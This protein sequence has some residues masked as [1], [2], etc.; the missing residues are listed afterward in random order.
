M[1]TNSN[2][3]LKLLTTTRE[4]RRESAIA[5]LAAARRACE[6]AEAAC[7]QAQL[8]TQQA[9]QWREEVLARCTLGEGGTLRDTVLPTCDALLAQRR[10]H[11][12]QMQAAWRAAHE[13][14]TLERQH[15]T[16]C[17]RDALRLEEW[18]QLHQAQER[19]QQAA[20]ENQQDEEL[21]LRRRHH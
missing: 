18:R 5:R 11:L 16:T 20:Q 7:E 21:P 10:Q 6:L 9:W 17:E 14:V 3:S 19:Q 15:L 13:Q 4:A 1:T 12:A 8:E 2:P